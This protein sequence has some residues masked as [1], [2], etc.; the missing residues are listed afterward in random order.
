MRLL[1]RYLLR[2]LLT[3]LAYCLC[4]FLV[5]YIAFDLIF[6]IK[7]F[8]DRRLSPV[9]VAEHYAV[10]LPDSLVRQI[11]PVSLLLAL[12]YALTDF[13]RHN[14]LTA[15]RAAGVS[16]GRLA[17]PYLAVGALLGIAS[18]ALNELVV[19]RSA[20][21]DHAIMERHD[22]NAESGDWTS[23]FSFHNDADGRQW[24]ISRYNRVTHEMLNPIIHWNKPDGTHHDIYADRGVYSDGQW[25]FTKVEDWSSQSTHSNYATLRLAFSE[26]P[27]WIN[28]EIKVAF[29]PV[30]EAAK[31]PLLSIHETLDYLRLHPRLT[32]EQSATLMTGLHCQ[33]AQPFTCLAV[34]LIALPFGA[35]TGRH[36]VFAGVASSVFICL[37]YFI[38][39]KFAMGL[40]IG[41]DLPPLL[42]GWLPNLLFGATGLILLWRLK[43]KHEILIQS[44]ECPTAAI[45][46]N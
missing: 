45:Q 27:A 20:E 26:T 34:V 12:L 39:Q 11:V 17:L 5:L 33:L 40:G 7:A 13:S 15:M 44:N 32:A 43:M 24:E 29:L 18:L 28:S 14:E 42:A 38:T 36:N 30:T 37:A 19:P 16:P 41:E 21:L 2:E 10:T 25:V 4:G 8:Q 6:D 3:P 22:P 35:R 23:K 1:D 46:S 31:K 9:E